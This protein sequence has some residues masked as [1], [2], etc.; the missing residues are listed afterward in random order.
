MIH[1]CLVIVAALLILE[2]G[3][4]VEWISDWRDERR[5]ERFNEYLTKRKRSDK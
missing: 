1:L 3:H 2:I 5:I 4:W